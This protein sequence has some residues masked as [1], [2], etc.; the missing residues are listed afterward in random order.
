[1][2][3]PSHA[4][5]LP[6]SLHNVPLLHMNRLAAPQHL[7]CTDLTGN[8]ATPE[9]CVA[10]EPLAGTHYHCIRYGAGYF[11]QHW[12]NRYRFC[13]DKSSRCDRDVF[14]CVSSHHA[15]SL[16]FSDV[17]ISIW[18]PA[19]CHMEHKKPTKKNPGEQARKMEYGV[20]V[21]LVSTVRC[22]PSSNWAAFK[23][24]LIR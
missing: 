20:G 6:K 4:A 1:M 24:Q 10:T 18:L 12:T 16:I 17:A 5:C 7:L 23:V 3:L 2:T 19:N 8:Y 22:Y 21:L 9:H 14:F 15:S 13:R 11:S